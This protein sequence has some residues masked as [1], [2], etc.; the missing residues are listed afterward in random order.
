MSGIEK[1]LGNWIGLLC[2]WGILLA[3]S[4]C[5]SGRFY[6][7]AVTG[8]IGLLLQRQPLQAVIEDKDRPAELRE[9]L[10][11]VEALRTFASQKLSLPIDGTYTSFVD[12]DRPYVVWNVAVCKEFDLKSKSWWYPVVGRLEHRGYFREKSG[13]RYAEMMSRRGYDTAV[14]GVIGYSTL[15][16]FSD[17]V[18]SSFLEL[19]EVDLAELI[20]HEL[21]HQ[22]LFINGDTD[23]NEAFAVS[24]AEYGVIQWLREKGDLKSERL[25]VERQDAMQVF[26]AL[27]AQLRLDLS[28]TYDEGLRLEWDREK[29]RSKKDATI[30][31]FRTH[32]KTCLAESPALEPFVNWVEGPINNAKINVLDTYYRLLPA[33]RERLSTA[34]NLNEFYETVRCL[35][36]IPKS[37]RE[38]ALIEGGATACGKGDVFN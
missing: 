16:W 20:F 25:V 13:R 23:F 17:P 37:L 9:K 38:K 6:S 3:T 22:L 4:G 35:G 2:C 5:E 19:D 7:Q 33:F 29:R 11:L 30:D 8:Q 36:E 24:V 34:G 10:R 28:D 31:A 21:A 1:Y 18:L 27:V 12:L 32:F 26:M 15:G 14:G